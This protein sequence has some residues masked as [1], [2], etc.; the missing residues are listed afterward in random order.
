MCLSDDAV[1]AFSVGRNE[2]TQNAARTVMSMTLR[3]ASVAAST[4][5]DWNTD[6]LLHHALFTPYCVAAVATVLGTPGWSLACHQQHQLQQASS[7]CCA[8]LC[9]QQQQQQ[10]Q[11]HWQHISTS[12]GRRCP[13][14]GHQHQQQPS[15]I[16]WY[17]RNSSCSGSNW[18]SNGA[19]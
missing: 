11:Q 12:S 5:V 8:C 4:S 15:N 6:C 19:R 14:L 1:L 2:Q 9:N 3:A 17:C 16:P 18:G 7:T 13:C 10:Q